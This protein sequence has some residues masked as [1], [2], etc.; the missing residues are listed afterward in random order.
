MRRPPLL[1]ILSLV[2]LLPATSG[3]ADRFADSSIWRVVQ[4]SARG[5]ELEVEIAAPQWSP[6]PGGGDWRVPGFDG[7]DAEAGRSWPSLHLPLA[8]PSGGEVT[9]AVAFE[10]LRVLPHR[11]EDLPPRTI[12]P[13]PDLDARDGRGAGGPPP[14]VETVDDAFGR[15]NAI[16]AQGFVARLPTRISDYVRLLPLRILPV[17]PDARGRLLSP[18][19]LR[20]TVRWPQAATDPAGARVAARWQSIVANPR[21]ATAWRA[22]PRS[23]PRRLRGDGFSS[24]TSDWLRIAIQRRGVY[25]ITAQQLQDAGVDPEG[26][27]LDALRLFCT[28]HAALPESMAVDELPDWMEPCALWIEDDGDSL[29]DAETRVYFVGNGPDGWRSDLGL[30]V[31]DPD[32]RYYQHP[33]TAEFV[34]WLCWGGDFSTPPARMELHGED[35]GGWPLRETATARVHFEESNVYKT[36]PRDRDAHWDPFFHVLI[37]AGKTGYVSLALP[38]ISPLAPATVRCA[39]FGA[40]WASGTGS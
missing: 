34:Y 8:V 19:R 35:P 7:R 22:A 16:D 33:H 10:G 28:S 20:I 2:L 36:R 38:G 24:A 13:P 5:L 30:P 12:S 9:V 21:G 6:G 29:W 4:E 40:S 17:R 1:R 32:D 18:E 11:L 23:A 27:P 15:W 39:A 37:R 3:A 26:I 31:G 25:G 14:T